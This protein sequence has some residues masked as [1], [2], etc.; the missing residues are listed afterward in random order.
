LCAPAASC[1]AVAL[2]IG[3][4]DRAPRIH[5]RRRQLVSVL[6]EPSRTT[7]AVE[8]LSRSQLPSLPDR[9]WQDA[10]GVAQFGQ[11]LPP[12]ELAHLPSAA[13]PL[14]PLGECET[15]YEIWR[16]DGPM[17]VGRCGLVSYRATA[18]LLFGCITI[19][20]PGEEEGKGLRASTS[21]AYAQIFATLESTGYRQL[22]RIW[23]YIPDIGKPAAGSERYWLFNSAR[24]DSFVAAGRPVMALAPAASALGTP[25]GTPL[26][27]YFLAHKS[28]VQ[29]LENPRQVSAYRYPAQY[30]PSSPSFSR[31]SLLAE[32]GGTL[33]VSGTSSIVGHK[34]VH[35]NDVTAQTRES[36]LNIG[37]L[38]DDA[39]RRMSSQRFALG[40]L[41]YKVYVRREPDLPKIMAV[42][43]ESVGSAARIAYMRADICRRD[44]LVEIEAMGAAEPLAYE[45]Q[46]AQLACAGG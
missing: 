32:G 19:A 2:C 24:H 31:A 41:S 12:L 27:I 9:W 23:N 39:S 45:S 35:S 22:M 8:Y 16:A 43:H 20:E 11:K 6:N 34:S 46:P 33:M 26:V 10:L 15:L 38:T 7:L 29:M 21:T 17:H 28:A 1:A 30:G 40:M 42:M 5:V 36:L 18:Q 44:L 14:C 13:V 4:I 37:A 3:P 25:F